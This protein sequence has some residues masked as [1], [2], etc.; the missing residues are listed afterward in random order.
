[1]P[2]RRSRPRELWLLVGLM[3]SAAF[4]AGVIVG[5]YWSTRL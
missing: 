3:V 5:L 4:A 1:M 2:L